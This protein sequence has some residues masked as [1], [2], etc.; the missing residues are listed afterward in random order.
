MFQVFVPGTQKN[1]RLR[2]S[3]PPAMPLEPRTFRLLEFRLDL[4]PGANRQP[5]FSASVV[6]AG[7][8]PIPLRAFTKEEPRE[9]FP[10]PWVRWLCSLG[11]SI[12]FPQISTPDLKS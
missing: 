2:Q 8:P 4:D 7:G 6:S 11:S 10:S 1:P 12:L 9:I 3:A 5:G